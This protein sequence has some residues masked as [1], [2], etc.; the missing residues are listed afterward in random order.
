MAGLDP[1]ILRG[2]RKITVEPRVQPEDGDDETRTSGR[3]QS[4]AGFRLS[5]E[6][7]LAFESIAAEASVNE[8]LQPFWA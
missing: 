3:M 7:R 4:E 2:T 8:V 5:P 6:L 1:A